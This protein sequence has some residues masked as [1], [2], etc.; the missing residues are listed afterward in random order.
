[1]STRIAARAA[2]GLSAPAFRDC[3]AAFF[4]AL[5][6]AS[7]LRIAG[8]DSPAISLS[9]GEA[10]AA[11]NLRM[12]DQTLRGTPRPVSENVCM[13]GLLAHRSIGNR[14]AFPERAP[15][16]GKKS[17]FACG[18]QLRGQ[19]RDGDFV[20]SFHRIPFSSRL[21]ANRCTTRCCVFRLGIVNIL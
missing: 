6:R 3:L 11:R 5:V 2:L 12:A 16:A 15:V 4:V 10:M 13:A 1:M 17:Q 9:I 19:L 21:R 7:L 18:L 14:S 8:A 20:K